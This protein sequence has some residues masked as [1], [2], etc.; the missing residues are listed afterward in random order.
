MTTPIERLETAL[1][2]LGLKAVEARLENLLEQASKK[3]PSYAE[4]LDELLSCEVGDQLVRADQ[5]PI[6]PFHNGKYGGYGCAM[7]LVGPRL[8]RWAHEPPEKIAESIPPVSAL[9]DPRHHH[10]CHRATSPSAGAQEGH[11]GSARR[12]LFPAAVSGVP[13]AKTR[14]PFGMDIRVITAPAADVAHPAPRLD[15][16]GG[17]TARRGVLRCTHH[18]RRD[19][20]LP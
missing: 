1:Q 7:G 20:A 13:L 5:V 16:A 8:L 6:P 19:N 11:T 17:G 9:G 14:F 15:P 10:L 12:A 3:E 18:P 4:F 2:T